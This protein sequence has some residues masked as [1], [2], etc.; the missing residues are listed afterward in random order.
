METG[1]RF[2]LNRNWG[3]PRSPLKTWLKMSGWWQRTSQPAQQGAQMHPRQFGVFIYT[4]HMMF[5]TLR[6][7]SGNRFKSARKLNFWTH[8]CWWTSPFRNMS[9]MDPSM[10]LRRCILWEAFCFHNNLSRVHVADLWGL[11]A[12]LKIV[13]RIYISSS[14]F[15]MEKRIWLLW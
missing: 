12:I 6:M 5:P 9:W 1:A 14:H 4:N 8:W 7:C 3:S 2:C 10:Y 15:N 13:C 11:L